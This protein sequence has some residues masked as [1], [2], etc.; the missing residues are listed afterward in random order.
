[1]ATEEPVLQSPTPTHEAESIQP[2]E[3][4]GNSVVSKVGHWEGYGAFIHS[5][6]FDVTD[7]DTMTKFE[8][9]GMGCTQDCYYGAAAPIPFSATGEFET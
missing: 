6:K 5:V 1:M 3:G 2:A 9:V 4:S 8:L 7:E